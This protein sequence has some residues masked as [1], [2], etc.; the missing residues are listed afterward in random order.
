MNHAKAMQSMMDPQ[1]VNEY[2]QREAKNF[3]LLDSSKEEFASNFFVHC[4]WFIV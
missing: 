2:D 4:S 3:I 1:K